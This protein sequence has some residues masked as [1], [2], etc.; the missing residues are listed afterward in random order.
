MK[1]NLEMVCI[2]VEHDSRRVYNFELRI[3]CRTE[4]QECVSALPV[5]CCTVEGK[6]SRAGYIITVT[7]MQNALSAVLCCKSTAAARSSS[8][9]SDHPITEMTSFFH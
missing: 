3:T 1:T 4:S 5:C 7:V 8:V 6:M 9:L 2:Q